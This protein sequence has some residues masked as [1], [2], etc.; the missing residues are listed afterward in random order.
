MS[1]NALFVILSTRRARS[2]TYTAEEKWFDPYTVGAAGAT[3]PEKNN[4]AAYA[5]ETPLLYNYR[6]KVVPASYSRRLSCCTG[7]P[8]L[9]H[10]SPLYGPAWLPRKCDEI[11]G[12]GQR[13][14]WCLSSCGSAPC[15]L[16][17]LPCF[18][19]SLCPLKMSSLSP[20]PCL[21]LTS[22]ICL[23]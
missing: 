2:A 11:T 22:S 9:S 21:G 1:G 15:L 23:S 5:M 7:Q 6:M 12:A 17:V 4:N 19:C 20:S 8:F 3:G 10:A 18:L 13:N 16:P 14:G